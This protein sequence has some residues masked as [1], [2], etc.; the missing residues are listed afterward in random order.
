MYQLDMV[1]WFCKT[2]LD[3]VLDTF[4]DKIQE[5]QKKTG[6]KVYN[7]YCSSAYNRF[8]SRP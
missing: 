2:D 7:L 4:N 1:L 3:P 8:H 5:A 6:N